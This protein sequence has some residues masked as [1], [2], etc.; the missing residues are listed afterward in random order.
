MTLFLTIC[1]KQYIYWSPSIQFCGAYGGFGSCSLNTAP[2]R[3]PSPQWGV[4]ALSGESWGIPGPDG[5]VIPSGFLVVGKCP[6]G[7]LIRC[8]NHLRWLFSMWRSGGMTPI[9]LKMSELLAPLVRL[10][11]RLNWCKAEMEEF[12]RFLYKCI[13]GEKVLPT[14]TSILKVFRLCGHVRLCASYFA[15]GAR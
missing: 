12:S 14:Y 10:I 4:P 15:V 11:P 6:G 7:F 1:Y 8:Q 2:H 9:Y 13:F 3:H 5:H